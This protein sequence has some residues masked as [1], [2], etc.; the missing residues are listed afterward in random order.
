LP[1]RDAGVCEEDERG[2]SVAQNLEETAPK[3]GLEKA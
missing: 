1:D 2:P 3:N